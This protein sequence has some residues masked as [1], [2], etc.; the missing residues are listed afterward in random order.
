LRL[1]WAIT[2]H[3]S[4]GLTFDKMIIDAE[5]AFAIGQVYVALSRCTSLEGLILKTPINNNFLGAHK[6]FIEWQKKNWNNNL[7]QIFSEARQEFILEELQN[8]FTWKSWYYE[9]KALNEFITENQNK[10]NAEAI[11]WIQE[12][13]EKQNELYEVSEKF[14]Q[15]IIQLNNDKALKGE[16][17]KFQ[18][19]IKDGANYFHNEIIKWRDS[20]YNHPLSL[21]TKKLSRKAD[22]L[23]EDICFIVDDILQKINYCK[24]GFRLDDYLKKRKSLT[25]ETN[26]VKSSYSKNQTVSSLKF[27]NTVEETVYYLHQG[28]T[29]Q[30]IAKERNLVESTI[31]IHLAKAINQN[32]IQIE[33][34]MQESDVKRIAEYFPENL[35]DVRLS[36][37]KEA[38]PP[39]INYSDLRIVLAW[40]QKEK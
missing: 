29:I 37:I 15:M 1:A 23:L 16:D 21:A 2:I 13:I 28:K 31:K 20:F 33:E 4:Q 40:L 19:R 38:V 25:R 10:I 14:K 12:L 3:K 6:D 24:D 36:S 18:K 8:I 32:L 27:S 9:L 39:E 30:Q 5:R 17:E 7:V 34:V 11:L 22:S 26:K 35:D